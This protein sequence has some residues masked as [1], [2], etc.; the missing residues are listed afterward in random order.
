MFRVLIV[1]DEKLIREGLSRVID[2]ES[3]GFTVLALAED[4]EEAM[5]AYGNVKPHL[6]VTDVRMPGPDGLSLIE[7]LRESNPDLRVL[8][9][10]GHAD[11]DYARR[12]LRSRVDGYLLKPVD[13]DELLGLVRE[14]RSRLLSSAPLSDPSHLLEN[15]A[16][17]IK[18]LNTE[19]EQLQA[20]GNFG[21]GPWQVL[22]VDLADKNDLNRT[23]V[24]SWL[25]SL[26][27]LVGHQRIGHCFITGTQAAVLLSS[28]WSNPTALAQ[29][30]RDIFRVLNQDAIISSGNARLTMA[31]SPSFENLTDLPHS[32]TEAINL[33]GRSFFAK[34]G[35][36]IERGQGNIARQADLAAKDLQAFATDLSYL[37]D[38]RNTGGFEAALDDY[39]Q[40]LA[41]S[42]WDEGQFKGL[43]AGLA[44][45]LTDRWASLH[46]DSKEDRDQA[47]LWL[48]ALYR[49]TSALG[50]VERFKKEILALWYRTGP[51]NSSHVA[52]RLETLIQNHYAEQLHLDELSRAFGYN[53]AYL[54]KLY[55]SQTGMSFNSR[56]DEIRI[57]K[58]KTFL[59]EGFKV[60]QVARMVGFKDP[61]YF[62]QKFK[63]LN[64]LSPRA[65]KSQDGG[66]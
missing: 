19:L 29:L 30:Y 27:R 62:L 47:S 24:I 51:V 1:D 65:W 61:E 64:G 28:P 10:S 6:L 26:S 22:V 32:L 60:H 4:Y 14:I 54:G 5:I 48:G 43:M 40:T 53:S 21:P 17:G 58:A 45:M 41:T 18:P 49:E 46:P 37:L 42:T 25:P 3:E 31:I 52:E 66:K 36:I 44:S 8:I 11:F 50:L 38:A 59:A 12:A 23:P 56:L 55:K 34:E 33:L 63:K 15:F 13:E 9:L 39:T 20:E 2:W 16:K 7:E 57:A 35:I